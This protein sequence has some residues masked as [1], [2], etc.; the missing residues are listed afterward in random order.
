MA[1]LARAACLTNFVD[2]A[3]EAGLDPRRLLLEFRLPPRCLREPEIKIPVDAVRRLLEAC[4]Q[5]SGVEAFGL[6]MAEKRRLSALGP[7]GML[8]REQPTLRLAVEALARYANRLNEALFLTIENA[9]DVVVLREELIVGG[10]G[11]VRQSTELAIGVAF[12]SLQALIGAG[13]QPL[14]VCFAHDAPTDL[15]V[16]RRVFG[17]IVEF[18]H[19][20]N[21][22][23][24]DRK[25]IDALNPHADP[26]MARYARSLVE[27]D[28][29]GKAKDM[30][31]E[32]RRLVVTLLPTGR[33]TIEAAALHL[34]VTR[35]T[36]HRRLADERES[37]SGIVDAVRRELAVR[38][39]ADKQRTLAQVSALLGFSAPSGFT[40]WYRR[41]FEAAPSERRGGMARGE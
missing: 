16:H 19:D 32:V 39:V 17:R 9:G 40:R 2:V 29:D 33:C 7:L 3:R 6:M 41:H 18:G 27:S 21:G 37:F 35:R 5:R 4:A 22:I 23:V 10:S 13:W 12:R 31:S 11:P 1:R 30:S 24:C 25:Q 8:M 26:M 38:Y 34:G 36:I 14:R 15:S 28:L 20:F